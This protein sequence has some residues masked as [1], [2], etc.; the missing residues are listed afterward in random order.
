MEI[1][2][3][4]WVEIN[5]L[6]LEHNEVRQMM[7]NIFA[8]AQHVVAAAGLG[9]V[10]AGEQG[11]V[12]PKHYVLG[13]VQIAECLEALP[14]AVRDMATREGLVEEGGEAAR[15]AVSEVATEVTGYFEHDATGPAEESSDEGGEGDD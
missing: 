9:R 11:L 3:A 4:S 7:R 6:C 5:N 15:K 12:T 10:K 14:D 1:P 2:E 8:Q 13:F